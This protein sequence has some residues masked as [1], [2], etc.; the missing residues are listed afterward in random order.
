MTNKVEQLEARSLDPKAAVNQ[1]KPDV[2]SDATVKPNQPTGLIDTSEGIIADND[3][4]ASND[5]A[6]AAVTLPTWR[7]NAQNA[8]GNVDPAEGTHQEGLVRTSSTERNR[9]G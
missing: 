9:K 8:L 7:N 6:G 4:Q 3:D 2:P 5:N 1:P